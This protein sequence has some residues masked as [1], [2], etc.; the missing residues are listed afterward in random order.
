MVVIREAAFNPADKDTEVIVAVSSFGRK[1]ST[2]VFNIRHLEYLDNSFWRHP[3]SA[4][5]EAERD[6]RHH[7][8]VRG[9]IVAWRML[10][11][12]SGPDWTN[13]DEV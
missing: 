8:N 5:V 2:R 9:E 10:S 6:G 3:V 7:K 13:I 4:V 11:K 12:R 1:D